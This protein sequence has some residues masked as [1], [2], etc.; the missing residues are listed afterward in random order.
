[1][2]NGRKGTSLA[3]VKTSASSLSQTTCKTECLTI[4]RIQAEM[5]L[6]KFIGKEK[7]VKVKKLQE[8]KPSVSHVPPWCPQGMVAAAQS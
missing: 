4:M 3:S 5:L 1:M 2:G 6:I 7:P 8:E